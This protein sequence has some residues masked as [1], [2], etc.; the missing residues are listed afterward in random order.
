M[1]VQLLKQRID[2]DPARVGA[3][4]VFQGALEPAQRL[5]LSVETKPE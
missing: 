3:V 1:A 4:A 5:I 2:L